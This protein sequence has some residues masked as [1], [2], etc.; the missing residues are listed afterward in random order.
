MKR[1]A[2]RGNPVTAVV[3]AVGT[4]VC[5]VRALTRDSLHPI[6]QWTALEDCTAALL[7]TEH[8]DAK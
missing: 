7:M 1:G 8:D 2:V 3:Q 5:N 6:P 4:G